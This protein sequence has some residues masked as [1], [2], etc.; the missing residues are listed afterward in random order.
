VQESSVERNM[1]N[2]VNDMAEERDT[3]T[4]EGEKN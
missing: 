3:H 1:E 4:E 2:M